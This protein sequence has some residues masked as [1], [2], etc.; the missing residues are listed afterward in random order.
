MKQLI[1][2]TL[3][4]LVLIATTSYY[5]WYSSKHHIIARTPANTVFSIEASTANS[6]AEKASAVY[7]LQANIIDAINDDAVSAQDFQHVINNSQSVRAS[8]D[9]FS[10]IVASELPQPVYVASES[11]GITPYTEFSNNFVANI[12]GSINYDFAIQTDGSIRINPIEMH[13]LAVDNLEELVRNNRQIRSSKRLAAG[14]GR[15]L[16]GE[17]TL[18]K[19][20][21]KHYLFLSPDK[22]EYDPQQIKNVFSNLGIEASN[23]SIFAHDSNW[24]KIV[25]QYYSEQ[26]GLSRIKKKH[27]QLYLEERFSHWKRTLELDQ[28]IDQLESIINGE[29]PATDSQIFINFKTKR[30]TAAILRNAFY[31]YTTKAKPPKNFDRYVKI[32]GKLNDALQAQNLDK[33]Q[34]IAGSLRD[35][36]LNEAK[37]NQLELDVEVLSSEKLQKR[38]QKLAQEIAQALEFEELPEKEFHDMRKQLKLLL[39]LASDVDSDQATHL[40]REQMTDEL[41]HIVTRLGDWHD[42]Y[43]SRELQGFH[44]LETYSISAMDRRSIIEALERTN[45]SLFKQSCHSLMQK[46]L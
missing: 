36:I 26:S 31:S 33:S 11:R 7:N 12:D 8:I 25:Y 27:M 3:F 20:G 10:Q 32:F 42:T 46:L 30:K 44:T 16:T 18:Y 43:I 17:F 4:I 13:E 34:E 23:I 37:L 21:D 41:D 40:V 9:E 39:L 5:P 45:S 6:S 14:D 22:V 19:N 2:S 29:L 15:L 38:M 1:I 35:Y 28:L 24:G